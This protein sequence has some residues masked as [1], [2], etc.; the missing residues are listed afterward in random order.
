MEF[1]DGLRT[2]FTAR[3]EGQGDDHVITVPEREL[4][5]GNLI[6]GAAYRIA[7]FPPVEVTR[8]QQADS[9]SAP[10]VSVGETLEVEIEDLGDKGDGIARIGPGYVIFVPETDVGD[11]VRI[12]ITEAVDNFAFGS[13]IEAEPE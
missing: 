11:R 8:P 9:G 12:E 3:I 7:I 6:D 13:V 10:P 1:P 2:L 4:R 5:H